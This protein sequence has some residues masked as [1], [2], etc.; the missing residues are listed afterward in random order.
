MAYAGFSTVPLT[1]TSRSSNLRVE[2]DP[3]T[4]LGMRTERALDERHGPRAVLNH[5]RPQPETDYTFGCPVAPVSIAEPCARK[6][7]AL[8]LFRCGRLRLRSVSGELTFELFVALFQ[9]R[10][11]LLLLRYLGLRLL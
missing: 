11:Q 1:G 3:S 10:D 7:I 8:L 4:A 9:R 2:I 6:P 5:R